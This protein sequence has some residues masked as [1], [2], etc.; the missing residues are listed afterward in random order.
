M[1]VQL[2]VTDLI[3]IAAIVMGFGITVIMFRLQRELEMRDKGEPSWIAYSDRLILSSIFISL[4][5][6]FLPIFV[7]P[8]PLS[9]T[10]AHAGC[11]AAVVLQAGFI[12]SI[13]AHYRLGF[14]KNR[15]GPRE[16]PEP[17]E[18]LFV[19]L[20]AAVAILGSVLTGYRR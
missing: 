9:I 1:P 13:L 10:L 3:A 11:F 2:A 20:S 18:R 17:K 16:N 19:W 7:L 12:P 8:T 5:L 4:F 14:G 6:V 15:T